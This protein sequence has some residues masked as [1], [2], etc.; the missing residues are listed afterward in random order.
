VLRAVLAWTKVL[1][2]D[3]FAGLACRLLRLGGFLPL[4]LIVQAA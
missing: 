2:S 4:D 1:S 3:L